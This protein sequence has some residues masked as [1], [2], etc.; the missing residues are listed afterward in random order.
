MTFAQFYQQG[1]VFMHLITLCVIGAVASIALRTREARRSMVAPHRSKAALDGGITPW[2][3]AAGVMFGLGGTLMGFI[4]LCAALRTIP[5][6]SW[7]LALSRGAEISVY[8]LTWAMMCLAP[9]ALVH[10]GLRHFERRMKAALR[11]GTGQA[12]EA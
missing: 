12:P 10:G 5:V 7:P 3:L 11:A 8:P 2:L 4:E 6:E 1:G 9:L